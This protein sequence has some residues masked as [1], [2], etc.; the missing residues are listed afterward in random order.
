MTIPMPLLD[1]PLDSNRNGINAVTGNLIVA[2]ATGSIIFDVPNHDSSGG[3]AGV[4]DPVGSL[5]NVYPDPGFEGNDSSR[6]SWADGT[7]GTNGFLGIF[8]DYPHTGSSY[9]QT[10]FSNLSGFTLIAPTDTG[11]AIPGTTLVHM[12]FWGQFA[13][14]GGGAEVITV[15]G[16]VVYTDTSFDDTTVAT[17]TALEGAYV[18]HESDLTTNPAKTID[19]IQLRVTATGA[20]VSSA[21]YYIDDLVIEA[22][23]VTTPAIGTLRFPTRLPSYPPYTDV[24]LTDTGAI[25]LWVQADRTDYWEDDTATDPFPLLTITTASGEADRVAVELAP[26]NQTLT[27]TANTLTS[28]AAFALT[29]TDTDWHLLILNYDGGDYTLYAD[30]EL[31]TTLAAGAPMP[32]DGDVYLL[33]SPYHDRAGGHVSNVTTYSDTLTPIQRRYLWDGTTPAPPERIGGLVRTGPTPLNIGLTRTAY[34]A[35]PIAVSRHGITEPLAIDRDGPPISI[36]ITSTSE[37][38]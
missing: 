20:T 17:V 18:L 36:A 31:I 8:T 33:S 32:V 14:R 37:E 29:D 27:I 1:L 25:A 38:L 2:P 10:L 19:Q 7:F 15:V 30:N 9:L 5:P 23:G 34:S 4:G 26:D 22:G 12:A 13:S 6:F 16:R 28:S 11:L 24:N 3:Y 35:E 21:H